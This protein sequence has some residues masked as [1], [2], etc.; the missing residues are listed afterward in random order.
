MYRPLCS[1]YGAP[2]KEQDPFSKDY[3]LRNAQGSNVSLARYFGPLLHAR[4]HVQNVYTSTA[5]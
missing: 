2:S 4:T 3:A 5:I 1:F